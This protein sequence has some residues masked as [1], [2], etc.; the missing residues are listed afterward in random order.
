MKE[1]YKHP[2]PLVPSLREILREEEF[3]IGISERKEILTAC[4]N[5][6]KATLEEQEQVN[7]YNAHS[8]Y[9]TIQFISCSEVKFL[10]D[11]IFHFLRVCDFLQS[12]M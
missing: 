5:G 10:I 12:K 2:L 6:E 7:I 4:E 3:R 1:Q 9:T 8:P 11:R